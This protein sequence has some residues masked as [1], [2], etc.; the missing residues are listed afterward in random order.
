MFSRLPPIQSDLKMLGVGSISGSEHALVK[1]QAAAVMSIY[2]YTLTMVTVDSLNDY[3][4][5]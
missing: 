3:S 4:I 1:G 2:V 5:I